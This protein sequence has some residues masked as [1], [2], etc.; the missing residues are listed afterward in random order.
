ML[1]Y[2]DGKEISFAE[3]KYIVERIITNISI[4]LSVDLEGGYGKKASEIADY[5]K[6]LSDLGVVG[7]NIEDS[8][9]NKDRKLRSIENFSGIISEVKNYLKKNN[10]NLFVNIRTDP[11]LLGISNPLEE[12][13]KRISAFEQA[14]ADG[15][16]I[17]GII[18]EDDIKPV[19]FCTKLPVNVKC[20]PYLPSFD[21]L[22]DLGVKRLSMGN[23]VHHTLMNDLEKKIGK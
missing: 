22:K 15:I 18:D 4:P 11:F 6:Q 1:G 16:F 7:V 10:I 14:G 9:V 12:A 20:M 19:T 2:N 8:L 5:I 13:L 23:F 21:V 3:L 17:P